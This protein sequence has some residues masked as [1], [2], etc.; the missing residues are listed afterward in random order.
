MSQL[1]DRSV[2]QS[3]YETFTV[4]E[5]IYANSGELTV[6]T[7]TRQILVTLQEYFESTPDPDEWLQDSTLAKS[8]LRTRALRLVIQQLIDDQPDLPVRITV[9]L[10]LLQCEED[11]GLAKLGIQSPDCLSRANSEKLAEELLEL[12]EEARRNGLAAQDNAGLIM[13]ACQRVLALGSRLLQE[14]KEQRMRVVDV[15]KEKETDE[16]LQRVWFWFPSL[17]TREKRRDLVTYASRWGLT[18]FVLAGKPG[19]LCLEG[20]AKHA[21][22]YMSAIKSESWSDIPSY[23]KKV[24]ERYRQHIPARAFDSMSEITETIT[25]HGQRGNRG[26]MGEVKA[27]MEQKGVGDAF[28]FVVVNGGV[29]SGGS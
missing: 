25:Q 9:E 17:S 5:S 23:Q 21:E 2:I 14:E 27:F 19:L 7:E 1:I 16:E 3:H 11:G 12:A 22:A 15:E 26:D 10:P 24:T 18:G 28:G 8:L 6:D 4:C 29:G 13:D 20:T